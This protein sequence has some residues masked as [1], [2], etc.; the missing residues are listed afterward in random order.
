VATLRR[1]YIIMYTQNKVTH[2]VISGNFGAIA[3][4]FGHFQK[5]AFSNFLITLCS[6]T[7]EPHSESGRDL[8]TV[9]KSFRIVYSI[10]TGFENTFPTVYIINVCNPAVHNQT[11]CLSIS[12]DTTLRR[13]GIAGST[14]TPDIQH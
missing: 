10:R 12:I 2:C 14:K 11:C 9:G 8:L 13:L 7:D 4:V 6:E 5:H 1:I 3:P